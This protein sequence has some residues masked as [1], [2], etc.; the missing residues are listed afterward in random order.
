MAT[1][2]KINGGM[3]KVSFGVCYVS[4]AITFILM[5]MTIIDVVMRYFFHSGFKGN[6]ELTEI[7]IALIVFLGLSFTQYVGGHVHVDIFVNMIKNLRVRFCWNGIVRIITAVF[8]AFV[9]YAVFLRAPGERTVTGVLKVPLGPVMYIVAIGMA[10]FTLVLFMDGLDYFLQG[11]SKEGPKLG[12]SEAEILVE[13]A[14]SAV[15]GQ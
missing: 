8:S 5:C 7:G 14:E 13:E 4:M 1:F 2:N 12:K 3:R 6:I 11:V 15:G 10:F 9:T